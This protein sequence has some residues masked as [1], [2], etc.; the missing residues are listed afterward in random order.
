VSDAFSFRITVN[1]VSFQAPAIA[2]ASLTALVNGDAS[3]TPFC[4]LSGG[5][6]LF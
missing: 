5:T 6:R 3:H 1:P 4:A 2:R